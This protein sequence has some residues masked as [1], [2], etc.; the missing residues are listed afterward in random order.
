MAIKIERGFNPMTDRYA[1]DFRHCTMDA[2]WAQL[3]T[4]QDASYYGTWASPSARQIVNYCE[5]DITR[6]TADTDDEFVQAVREWE[7][8][9][10]GAGHGP[11]RIDP[12]FHDSALAGRFARLGLGDLCGMETTDA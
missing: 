12:G 10:N 3:D 4:Q 1:F 9:V 6:T 7:T 8:W 2:G 5:G 11:A